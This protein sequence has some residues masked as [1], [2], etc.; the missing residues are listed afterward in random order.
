[1]VRLD[2]SAV[3]LHSRV[4]N[5]TMGRIIDVEITVHTQ[6]WYSVENRSYTEM[7]QTCMCSSTVLHDQPSSSTEVSALGSLPLLTNTFPIVRIKIASLIL[8]CVS[9]LCVEVSI[10][11]TPGL[12][13][14]RANY[15]FELAITH[16]VQPT[17]GIIMAL[18][19]F[20]KAFLVWKG[21]AL[22]SRTS[23]NLLET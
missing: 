3:V 15:L 22:R 5:S 10:L 19:G 20:W 1:V 16:S 12:M 23:M 18:I 4:E 21:Q 17:L 6:C 7:Q 8:N 2:S 14:S 13:G 11:L 9:T